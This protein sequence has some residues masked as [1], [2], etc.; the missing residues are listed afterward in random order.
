M[1]INRRSFLKTTT[2]TLPASLLI[3]RLSG[4]GQNLQAG[5]ARDAKILAK[6][7]Q[8][9]VHDVY[10]TKP[11]DK[12]FA[13]HQKKIGKKLKKITDKDESGILPACTNCKHFKNVKDGWGTCSMVKA[14]GDGG[15]RVFEKGWCKVWTF[16]KT[17]AKQQIKNQTA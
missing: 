5:E 14:T 10:V 7:T 16:D 9:Y 15:P 1:N 12:K 2:F 8:G 3:A 4:L 11:S 17:K 6:K 13:K